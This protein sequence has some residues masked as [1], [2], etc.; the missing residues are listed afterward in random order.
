MVYL[1]KWMSGTLNFWYHITL[2]P[3]I[4]VAILSANV[5]SNKAIVD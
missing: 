4:T 5:R 3:V 2:Y 1:G